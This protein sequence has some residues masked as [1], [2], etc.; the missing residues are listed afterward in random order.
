MP[1][2][3]AFPEARLVLVEP[4][5]EAVRHLEAITSRFPSAEHVRAAA[6]GRPGHVVLNVHR[7]IARTSRYWESDYAPADVTQREVP[8]VTLDEVR[9]DRKLDG[10]ILLKIDVEG[11][12]LD[13]LD[14]ARE[15]LTDTE[16]VILEASLFEFHRGAP[17]LADVVGYMWERDFV[18][19]DVLDLQ[20]RPLDGAMSMIDL[21]FVKAGGPLRRSHR[22]Q[23]GP[24]S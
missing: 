1:L 24:L 23:V 11:A 10:P 14:G 16:Y 7:D 5:E 8:A 9:R 12:E 3:E 21:A 15:T 20:H 17:L 19:Y 22:F 4:V 18:L 6:A 2:Y 13:V